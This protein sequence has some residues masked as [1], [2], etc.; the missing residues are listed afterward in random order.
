MNWSKLPKHICKYIDNMNMKVFWNKNTDEHKASVSIPAI[1]CD[2][3][4]RPKW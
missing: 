2:K 3:I 4:C 1:P